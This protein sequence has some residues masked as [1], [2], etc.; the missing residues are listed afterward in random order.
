[1]LRR[2]LQRLPT[3]WWA[4]GLTLLFCAVWWAFSGGTTVVLPNLPILAACTPLITAMAYRGAKWL[5]TVGPF[6]SLT[7]VS[8]L[9]CLISVRALQL[10]I[11]LRPGVPVL[12]RCRREQCDRACTGRG[13]ARWRRPAGRRPP[14]RL[15]SRR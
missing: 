15:T 10:L 14:G 5:L 7:A 8:Y 13:E 9:A 3:E 6:W 12:S 2:V 11:T 4:A 1:M